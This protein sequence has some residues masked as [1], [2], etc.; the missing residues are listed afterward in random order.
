MPPFT[1]TLSLLLLIGGVV[2]PTLV[3]LRW[4]MPAVQPLRLAPP[5][6]DPGRPR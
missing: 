3:Y 4:R 1:S 2:V 5:H 6:I